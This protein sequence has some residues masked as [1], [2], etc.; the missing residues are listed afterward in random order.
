MC[1]VVA[2]GSAWSMAEGGTI[3]VIAMPD[4]S[5]CHWGSAGNAVPGGKA[6]ARKSLP[7]QRK[8]VEKGRDSQCRRL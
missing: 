1:R 6:Y 4:V 2:R 8:S 7:K 3:N 5:A